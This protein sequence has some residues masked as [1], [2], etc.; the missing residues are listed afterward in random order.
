MDSAA[1][2]PSNQIR[3][4]DKGFPVWDAPL[5]HQANGIGLPIISRLRFYYTSNCRII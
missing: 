4:M 1:C 2:R 3:Q 5:L